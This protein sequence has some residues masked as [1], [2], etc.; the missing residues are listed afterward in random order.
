MTLRN[1]TVAAALEAWGA[2]LDLD[3]ETVAPHEACGRLL[4]T[5]VV[6]GRPSPAVRC[7]AM[8]GYAVLA[9]STPGS[10]GPS[11]FAPIDTGAPIPE[12]FDAVVRR[13]V[14][15]VAED[16]LDVPVVTAGTDVRPVGEDFVAGVVLVAGG[17]LDPLTLALA[18]AGG[19]ATV[20][21]AR[22]A[23]V[24]IVP[25]GDEVVAAGDVGR[26]SDVIDSNSPMLA[27]QVGEAGGTPNVCAI[28][29]DD[30]DAIA[31]AVAAAAVDADLV[32]LVAGS[33]GGRRDHGAAVI[34]R[35][36]D[37]AVDGVA[38]RPG[39][40]VLLGHIS[41][42]PIVG[43]PGYP[44]SAAL[45]FELFVRPLLAPP[46]PQLSVPLGAAV[47]AG[48]VE[49][50]VP[51]RLADGAAWPLRTRA[52]SLAVLAGA[53][54]YVRVPAGTVLALGAIVVVSLFA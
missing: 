43:V 18:V 36:G 44:V 11:A 54:G 47:D 30:P 42:T 40:P 5:P 19:N 2:R 4:A 25:T 13:E 12:Q 50:V 1:V 8:D 22:R 17:V 39:H 16:R 33:S 24:A 28:V 51:V 7:A 49:R 37:L 27:A 38:V 6:A 35:L 52:S 32:L 26:P 53:D 3:A 20:A 48:P 10:L 45:T 29:P 15:V 46:R 31:G 41:G 23:R 34:R 14:A 9:S 21:V